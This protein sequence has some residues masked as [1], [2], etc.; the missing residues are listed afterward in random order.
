[1]YYIIHACIRA[2]A[3]NFSTLGEGLKSHVRRLAG[4]MALCILL[5]CVAVLAN[6]VASDTLMLGKA[7]YL[8]ICVQK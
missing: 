4:R 6:G 3:Q 1:M 8:G 5:L 2:H 7:V